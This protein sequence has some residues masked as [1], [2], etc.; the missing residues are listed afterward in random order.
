MHIQ[1]TTPKLAVHDTLFCDGGELAADDRY[2]MQSGFR[3]TNPQTILWILELPYAGYCHV[4]GR[5][6]K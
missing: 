2:N 5:R 6:L 4:P 1:V 3:G